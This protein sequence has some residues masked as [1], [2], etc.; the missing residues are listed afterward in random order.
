MSSQILLI[1]FIN[2]Q[3]I[4]ILIKINKE[5]LHFLRKTKECKKILKIKISAK[6]P[7]IIQNNNHK[8]NDN[9]NKVIIIWKWIFK[10][11]S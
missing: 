10:I 6:N 1:K 5:L 11:K 3:R 8:T 7:K 4:I 2:S 9:H